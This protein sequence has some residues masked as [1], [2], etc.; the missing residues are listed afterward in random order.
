MK[1]LISKIK[2]IDIISVL[3]I[4][5]GFLFLWLADAED[6]INGYVSQLMIMCAAFY[7]S[8]SARSAKKDETV[9]KLSENQPKE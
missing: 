7:F 2:T 5:L 4:V 1:S 9:Q 6:S 8:A 3:I